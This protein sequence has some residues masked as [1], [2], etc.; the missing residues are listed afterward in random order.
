MISEQSTEE[1]ERGAANPPGSIPPGCSEHA[2]DKKLG[3]IRWR[4]D[5]ASFGTLRNQRVEVPRLVEEISLTTKWLV[6]GERHGALFIDLFRNHTMFEAYSCALRTEACPGTIKVQ[7]L[8][9][10]SILMLQ[11]QNR[12]SIDYLLSI[13][14]PCFE[15]PPDLGNEDMLAYFVTLLKGLSMRI[16]SQHV[17][18]CLVSS[19]ATNNSSVDASSPMV[20]A[21]IDGRITQRMPVLNCAV[22]LVCHKDFMV[23]TAART[24]VLNILRVDSPLVRAIAEDVI[25]CSLAPNLSRIKSEIQKD[26]EPSRLQTCQ[27][28]WGDASTGIVAQ[29]NPMRWSKRKNIQET[30]LD[31][32]K[33]MRAHQ[34][35]P[36]ILKQF[37][38]GVFRECRSVPDA[39]AALEQT[40]R[41][42]IS[43]ED[44]LG[45]VDELFNLDNPAVAAALQNQGFVIEVKLAPL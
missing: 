11:M 43:I 45:F 18:Q 38:G 31:L 7:V 3:G 22:N 14:N 16:D 20:V 4:L 37:P 44:M 12:A 34:R 41:S 25:A 28:M 33:G 6:W 39:I 27:W 17:Q 23:Q 30:V 32:R 35:R 36:V 29:Y 9:S 2:L 13:L 5:A 1:T 8:Q 40:L 26:P 19:D 10:I 24:A 42:P 15:I 21:C